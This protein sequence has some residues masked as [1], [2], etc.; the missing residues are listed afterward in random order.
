MH[1]HVG[2]EGICTELNAIV[3]DRIVLD[4]AQMTLKSIRD[5]GIS[6]TYITRN[7]IR[8]GLS[9]IDLNFDEIREKVTPSDEG[10]FETFVPYGY[11]L[12]GSYSVAAFMIGPAI[13][14]MKKNDI[15][16]QQRGFCKTVTINPHDFVLMV[17]R[18]TVVN[19]LRR[20][21]LRGSMMRRFVSS[22]SMT[23]R[24]LNPP[25]SQYLCFFVLRKAC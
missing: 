1:T 2:A 21:G 3:E 15:D 23:A 8:Y 9:P 24:S 4:I 18:R 12:V 20:C 16:E 14:D 5:N 7:L 17:F 22:R 13:N 19:I 11:P 25:S 10:T 6:T